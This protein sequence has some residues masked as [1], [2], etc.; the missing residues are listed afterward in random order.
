MELPVARDI[1]KAF[2]L[3]AGLGTRMRPL[4]DTIPKPLV[5]LAGRP[6]LDHVL[7]RLETAGITEAI[8]N[9]HY[10]ADQ[11]EAHLRERR[12]PR[13]VFSDERQQLQETGGGVRKA[14]PMLGTAPFIVHNSDTVWLEHATS[15]LQRLIAMFDPTRMD[16]LLLLAQRS[17]SLGY[18]GH[19][20]FTLDAEARLA[21]REAGKSVDLVFAGASIATPNLMRETPDG[22]FS[23]N[24]VWDRAMAEKR[25]FGLILDGTWMHVGDPAARTDAETLLARS[26]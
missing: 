1:E 21:R 26:R 18:A 5:T 17:E 9:V 6:L 23:L 11:I 16:G 24:L 22:P 25:L 12:H 15:N 14:L 13:I 4:T 7:D 2:V 3:A 10:M 8:V 20:D 19:G